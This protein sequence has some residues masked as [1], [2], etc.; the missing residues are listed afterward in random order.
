M[1]IDNVKNIFK[2]VDFDATIFNFRFYTHASGFPDDRI[3]F[4]FYMDVNGHKV[5]D[6][7]ECS[8]RCSIDDIIS[9]IY[10]VRSSYK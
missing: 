10:Y 8:S 9:M 1:R 4:D 7:I 2:A 3:R 6:Y 5:Q